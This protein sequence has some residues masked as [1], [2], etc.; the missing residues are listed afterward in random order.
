MKTPH[1]DVLFTAEL[2]QRFL[3]EGIAA[4]RLSH[5]NIV[6]VL[7]VDQS[8]PVFYI[9]SAYS[10]GCSLA[11]WLAAAERPVAP[12]LAAEWVAALADAVEHAH[13]HGVLHR[14][15]K[16]SNVVLEP[17]P[18]GLNGAGAAPATSSCEALLPK[19]TDFGL[20]KLI[21]VADVRTR[22]G[23][24]VGTPAYMAPEQVDGSLGPIG[25]ATDIYGLGTVLYEMLTGVPAFESDNPAEALR[26]I[27]AG[28]FS[29]P[30]ERCREIPRDL[31]AICLRAMHLRPRRRYPSAAALAADLKRFLAGEM[32]QARPLSAVGRALKWA[33]RRPATATALA[34]AILAGALGTAG[35]AWHSVQLRRALDA[36]EAAQARAEQG[37]RHLRELVYLA[38]MREAHE[39][40]GRNELRKMSDLLLRHR[41]QANDS[42][43]GFLWR[44]LA[45]RCFGHPQ[46]AAAHRGHAH[47]V[48]FSSDALS[49]VTAG[50]DGLVRIWDAASG[51]PRCTFTSGA[52]EVNC[53]RFA[54]DGRSIAAAESGAG[55][56]L[57][58]VASGR[59]TEFW[60]PD[61]LSVVT[62][63]AW[64]PDGNRLAAAG[65][66]GTVTVVW[67]RG[68][69][70]RTVWPLGH[71]DEVNALAWSPDG[72]LLASGSSDATVSL[73][74]VERSS[75]RHRLKI[76]ETH[77]RSVCFSAD[78]R[79]LA[80]SGAHRL[81]KVWDLSNARLAGTFDS[82]AMRVDHVAF[83]PHG[84]M[85]AFGDNFG[86]IRTWDW[87]V[88]RL[89][90]TPSK[91][92]RAHHVAGVLV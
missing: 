17:L 80:T 38:D 46:R 57:W 22:T 70:D 69:G 10:E 20:A 6:S 18:A 51:Q 7:E 72:R 89:M 88:N 42:K 84:T 47:S 37:E 40:L 36:A 77:V 11:R 9:V 12:R 45:D 61:E 53:A 66:P 21:D 76:E 52:R 44:H 74:D 78:N 49:L 24:L 31:E 59:F 90:R 68:T 73:F 25:P 35:A 48:D 67:D 4:V 39:A 65:T 29:V 13:R 86:V 33:R 60:Q 23:V 92:A 82:G 16:P 27:T 75:I 58:D 34:V 55:V 28:E 87:Q 43:P 83:V 63:L 2:R 85:L 62:C 19:L 91:A 64:S 81:V 71:T 8:G 15:L 32:T 5:P 30:R 14:D 1:P 50:A 54:P 26:R 41:P 56:R 3:R 79:W